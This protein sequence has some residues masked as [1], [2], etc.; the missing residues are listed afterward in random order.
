MSTVEVAPRAHRGKILR[1]AIDLYASETIWVDA[2]WSVVRLRVDLQLELLF[3]TPKKKEQ[4]VPLI[5]L[6]CWGFADN[7]EFFPTKSQTSA[8]NKNGRQADSLSYCKADRVVK[9]LEYGN[10][11]LTWDFLKFRLVGKG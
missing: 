11:W 7:L 5:V 3:D 10:L 2:Q 4:W 1:L 8:P 6:F 9:V